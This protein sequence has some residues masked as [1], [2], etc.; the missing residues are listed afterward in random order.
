MTKQVASKK[1]LRIFALIMGAL[2][3]FVI[4]FVLPKFSYWQA[5]Y[6]WWGSLLLLLLI[7]L[8]K[9]RVLIPLYDAW[10]L[11]GDALARINTFITLLIVWLILFIPIGLIMKVCR[12]DP[13][14]RS[15]DHSLKSYRVECQTELE[16]S[17]LER[18]F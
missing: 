1:Q 4:G 8:I 7:G 15:F 2:I 11:L 5:N 16:K 18:P 6:Y 17:S 10:I 13:L 3:A 12:Y 14:K 9:P